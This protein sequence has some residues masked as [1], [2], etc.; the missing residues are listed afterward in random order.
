MGGDLGQAPRGA[1]LIELGH[2]PD[3]RASYVG[4]QGGGPG[5]LS[6]WCGASDQ[7]VSGTAA[8]PLR[9]D[10]RCWRAHSGAVSLC[11]EGSGSS[12]PRPPWDCPLPLKAAT[13]TGSEVSENMFDTE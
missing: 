11:A 13:P 7:R 2:L 8:M 5:S 3:L 6:A 1:S 4:G 10:P 9:A 12:F